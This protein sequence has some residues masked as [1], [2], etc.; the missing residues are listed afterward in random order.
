[1]LSL[2][3]AKLYFRDNRQRQYLEDNNIS[4]EL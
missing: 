2:D 3:G 4:Y 1:M